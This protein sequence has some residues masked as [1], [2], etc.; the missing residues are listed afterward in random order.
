LLALSRIIVIIKKF[1][2]QAKSGKPASTELFNQLSY[3]SGNSF[4]VEIRL[5]PKQAY[6]VSKKLIAN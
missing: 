2:W 5:K 4:W 6:F 3:S 1:I